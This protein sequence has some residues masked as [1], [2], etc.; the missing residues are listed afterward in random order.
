M[1]PLG[2]NHHETPRSPPQGDA[3][4]C[5]P[6][7]LKPAI[8]RNLV[9]NSTGERRKETMARACTRT[10]RRTRAALALVD[11]AFA[12]A[13]VLAWAALA[14]QPAYAYVDPSVMTYTI[15]ALAGVAVA[16]SAVLG[17]A[18]RRVR[19]W[20]LKALRVDEGAGKAT[21]GDVHAIDADDE[22]RDRLLAHADRAAKRDRAAQEERPRL[23]LPWRSRLILAL[24][25]C[26][27]LCFMTFFG[28][29][30]E[31]V[32]TNASSLS[33]G[34]ANVWLPLAAF[35]LVC[36]AAAALALSALRGRAFGAALGVLVALAVA[37]L[38]QALF[39][40]GDIPST[41]GS[42]VDWSEFAGISAASLAVWAAIIG[43]SVY[44]AAARPANVPL[45]TTFTCAALVLVQTASLG[46]TLATHAEDF[47]R[48][49]VTNEGLYSVSEKSNVIVLVLD[50]FDTANLDQIVVQYP[51]ALEEFA[52]FT[53]FHNSSG[54]A[55]PTRYGIPFLVT[56]NRITEDDDALTPE[57]IES[58]YTEHN[59]VDDALE[60]G[61][62]VGVYS[63]NVT[64]GLKLDSA[65]LEGRA[66]NVH[67]FSGLSTKPLGIV[68]ALSKCALYR[69]LPWLLKPLFRYYTGDVNASVLAED[70]QSDGTTPY[71]TD[72]ALYYSTLKD[73]RLAAD[74]QGEV[75]AFRFI[76]LRGAHFPYS[77]NEEGARCE[78]DSVSVE[79]Q[80]AG[81]LKIVSEYLIQLKELGVYDQSTIIVTADHGR[82]A[83]I[84][85][86]RQEDYP[87]ETTEPILLAKPAGASSTKA[88]Q[89]SEVPTGHEDYPATILEAM[90]AHIDDPTVFEVGNEERARLFN[91]TQELVD[92]GTHYD[93]EIVQYEIDGD[94][95]DY[96]NWHQ[97]G[98][99]WPV[100]ESDEWEVD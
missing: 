8:I 33:F 28:A 76:H 67:E 17:V 86:D 49:H 57:L 64:P 84:G 5:A 91:W 92:H 90:G 44:L 9:R 83:G 18:W 93:A 1:S 20:M 11:L 38:V 53:W 58:W 70:E 77:L 10:S 32:A 24:L 39:L 47:D 88:C 31:I 29:P 48:A 85:V 99:T 15:Q 71:K 59:L 80:G 16:M 26:G 46:I 79:Q 69:D 96:G 56:G 73:R 72:D 41:N 61:Y 81:V 35:T 98:I 51:D 22:G 66:L 40:N 97:T 7:N 45:A 63:E 82:L 42:A 50:M 25:A 19:R 4:L 3:R 21:E 12:A 62:S 89:R 87:L 55:I 95:F 75:G 54:S 2:I 23:N 52:G 78:E 60:Q 94:V 27:A 36:T 37:S 100:F 30:L 43:L 34:P 14:P 13:A 68:E 65:S 6:S 74:D